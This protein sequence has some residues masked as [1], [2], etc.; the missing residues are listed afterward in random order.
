MRRCFFVC[1]FVG[2]PAMAPLSQKSKIFASSPQG[3]PKTGRGER[4]G[5]SE[6]C[7]AAPIQPPLEGRW[8]TNVRRR[9]EAAA[10]KAV[11]FCGVPA[12]A[13]LSQKSKIFASSP[14]GEPRTGRGE[15]GLK[16]GRKLQ[17]KKTECIFWQIHSVLYCIL[18]YQG[19][20]DGTR[21]RRPSPH[22]PGRTRRSG[23]GRGRVQ[24]GQRSGCGHRQSGPGQAW[25][26]CGS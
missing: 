13:P 21:S 8:R 11:Q 9:G 22:H 14:Q 7:C 6:I 1:S 10:G 24:R 20:T 15:W 23:R 18:P 19:L 5:E 17:K 4:Q 2:R 12:M 16:T 26:R 3:E 25:P